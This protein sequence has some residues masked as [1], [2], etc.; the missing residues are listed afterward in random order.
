MQRTLR[1]IEAGDCEGA[2]LEL[3][4]FHQTHCDTVLA[5]LARQRGERAPACPPL[6]M[7]APQAE[8]GGRL[9]RIEAR[10]DEIAGALAETRPALGRW[11]EKA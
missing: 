5:E 3:R 9:A 11:K 10:L 8:E 2:E 1:L 7:S 6:A 4:A